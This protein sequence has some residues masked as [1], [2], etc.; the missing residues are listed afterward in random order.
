M[1]TNLLTAFIAV[2]K[3]K[4]FSMAADELHLTQPAISKR[5]ALLEGQLANTLFDRIGKQIQ[6]TEAGTTLLPKA[7]NILTE[8]DDTKRLIQNL[9]GN[10][11]GSLDIAT[12]HHIGLHHLPNILR[13]FAS[14]YP[15]VKLDIQFMGSEDAYD[16]IRRSERELAIITLGEENK[17]TISTQ[18]I[19][20]DPLSF[21]VGT[22]HPIKGKKTQLLELSKYPAILPGEE[23][24]T[25]QIVGDL[26]Q[27]KNLALD[28]TMSTN[29]LETIK[30]MVAVGL[31]WSVLP[32]SMLDLQTRTLNIEKINL[33]RDLGVIYHSNRTLS[34]AAKAFL[35]LLKTPNS[36]KVTSTPKIFDD[37]N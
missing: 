15:K 25:R 23:T 16:A 35:T 14:Q 29:Y 9:S 26:F 18:V 27:K 2:A 8:L 28:V 11:C 12:S 33:T 37:D 6:L 13:H 7:T 1:D 4:S 20:S 19:W 36:T 31:G 21:V 32:K 17:A 22:K 10:V 3:H 5:I 34:N 24:F 30:M